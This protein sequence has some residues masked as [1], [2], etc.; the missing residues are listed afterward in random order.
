MGS[1]S[2]L[3]LFN[4]TDEI[5]MLA[6][7]PFLA[8]ISRGRI[9]PDSSVEWSTPTCHPAINL[10]GCP[11]DSALQ[12]ASN[13]RVPPYVRRVDGTERSYMTTTPRSRARCSTTLAST[14]R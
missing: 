8:T 1:A 2:T 10:A 13:V 7:T 9:Q 5:V 3:D 6:R 14:T 4:N 11:V 12:I